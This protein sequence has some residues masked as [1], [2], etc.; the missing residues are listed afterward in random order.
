MA[1]AR[2]KAL[3]VED[4]VLVSMMAEANL[5][6]IG[7]DAVCVHTA[8][9]G[10]KAL[11]DR[12]NLALAVIDVGLPDMRGDDLAIKIRALAPH[13]LIVLATGYDSAPLIQQFRGDRRVAVLAK[14]YSE[15]DL[16]LAVASLG[17]E[18]EA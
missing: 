2:G 4:E 3:L 14:P 9:D 1:E 8:H 10:L 12:P 7:F 13:L 17:L 6:A 5:D 16:R 11:A 15:N 18:V